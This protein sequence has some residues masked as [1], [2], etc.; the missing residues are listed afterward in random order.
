MATGRKTSVGPIF[1]NTQP[2]SQLLQKDPLSVK[3]RENLWIRDDGNVVG[4]VDEATEVG[5]ICT[6]KCPL[7][8]RLVYKT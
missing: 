3:D 1:S 5:N 8:S 2:F 7:V 6:D 4:P